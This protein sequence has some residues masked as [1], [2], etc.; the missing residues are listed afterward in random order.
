M[1]TTRPA[2]R[3]PSGT[4]GS[5]LKTFEVLDTFGREWRPLSVAELCRETGQPKSSL[6]RV[7]STLVEAGVLEQNEH[8]LYYLTLK[9]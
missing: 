5:V 7:L 8:G 3:R 1:A 4:M 2:A 6:H 9:L